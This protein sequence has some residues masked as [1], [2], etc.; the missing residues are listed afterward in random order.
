MMIPSATA[1]IGSAQKKIAE[2]SRSMLNAMITAKIIIIGER[3]AM[4][5][6]IL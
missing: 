4:R 3:T 1:R 5:I 6:I 2:I